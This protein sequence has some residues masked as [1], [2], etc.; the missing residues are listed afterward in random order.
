VISVKNNSSSPVTDVKLNVDFPTELKV[1]PITGYFFEE[2]SG[3]EEKGFVFKILPTIVGKTTIE[4]EI[5]FKDSEGSEHRE[6]MEA[7][8]L[9]EVL[10]PPK[11]IEI[12]ED[13]SKSVPQEDV[14]RIKNLR[15]FKKYVSSIITP[16]EISEPEYVSMTKKFYHVTKGYTLKDVDIE[17]VSKHILEECK[18]AKLVGVHRFEDERLYL[19]SGKS[20]KEKRI[21][22]LTVVVK[23]DGKLVHLA[24]KLYSDIEEN[25]EDLLS[26]IAEII[27]HT[28]V[29]M[30]LAK[31]IEKIEVKKTI[32]IIDSIV[33]R[34][35]IGTGGGTEEDKEIEVKDS[36]V[37][38][39]EL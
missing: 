6:K 1:K 28:I 39:T 10:E 25:L 37:R 30:S 4:P 24:F 19:F 29:I 3:N 13:P 38:R 18:G 26:K 16:F 22:L 33:Q 31:E 20:T 34:S 7:F 27:K 36:V 35:D 14:E 17:T 5:R 32:N 11:N 2:I 8:L 9:E 23:G 15:E 12:R 21:Y